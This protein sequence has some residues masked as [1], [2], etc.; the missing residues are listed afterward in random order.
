MKGITGGYSRRP[1]AYVELIRTLDDTTLRVLDVLDGHDDLPAA[2]GTV[3]IGVRELARLAGRS[4][5]PVRRALTELER[6]GLIVRL[7]HGKRRGQWRMVK[8]ALPLTAALCTPTMRAT[9]DRDPKT[10]QFR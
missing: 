5:G 2:P 9:H 1:R 8:D 6:R 4:I 10:G 7:S 3:S